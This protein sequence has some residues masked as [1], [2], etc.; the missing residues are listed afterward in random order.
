M[1]EEGN[2]TG[3]FAVWDER[4]GTDYVFHLFSFG[5]GTLENVKDGHRTLSWAGFPDQ[6]HTL[7]EVVAA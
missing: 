2:N 1:F 4:F 5:D 7:D 6:R 3:N